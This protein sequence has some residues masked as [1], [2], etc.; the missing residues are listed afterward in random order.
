MSINTGVVVAI[1]SL[2]EQLREAV[3]R[4]PSKRRLSRSA[5]VDLPTL[6]RFRNRKRSV[7]LSTAD[8][9]CRALGL[10]LTGQ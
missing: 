10:R 7:S 3:E 9:L 5:D 4:A 8:K 1:P 2:T 6:S